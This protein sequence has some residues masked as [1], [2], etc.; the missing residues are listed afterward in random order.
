MSKYVYYEADD[1]KLLS[2]LDDLL[3][4]NNG[5]IAG[6][7]FKNVF[8]KEKIKD[9]DMFFRKKDD[10]EKALHNFENNNDYEKR[11]ENKKV[12]AFKNTKTNLIVELI[13]ESYISPENLLNNFDFTITKFAY[14]KTK[15]NE[16]DDPYVVLMSHKDFFQH[17]HLKR[18]VIDTD[19]PKPFNTFERALRYKGYG[20]DLCKYSKVR[21]IEAIRTEPIF[22]SVQLSESLYDGLD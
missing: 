4:N 6:G 13:K 18:L 8:N 2:F 10:Y 12:V 22:D 11:Y 17:L 3:L 21:L 19:L 9:V 7:L 5:I 16:E 14:Y 20:Y 15:D 1:F